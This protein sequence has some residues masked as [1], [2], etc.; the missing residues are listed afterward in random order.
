M[1]VC[2]YVMLRSIKA[3]PK[4]HE[5]GWERGQLSQLV[6]TVL[7]LSTVH[8]AARVGWMGFVLITNFYAY[9]LEYSLLLFR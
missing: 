6:S 2:M 7:Y 4:T 9:V 3:G 1:Y 8:V 5:P